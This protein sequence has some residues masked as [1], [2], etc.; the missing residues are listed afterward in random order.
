[1][2][3]L[4]QKR[5]Y[6][7]QN[8]MSALPPIATAKADLSQAVMSALPQKRTF[9]AP[10][11][12]RRTLSHT[13]ARISRPPTMWYIAGPSPKNRMESTTI[14]IGRT[15]V[16]REARTDPNFPPRNANPAYAPNPGTT[17]RKR[18]VMNA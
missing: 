2:S 16:T 1:M 13:A 5:T 12:H 9:G 7:V 3:A 6:A 14:D 15:Y 10:T 18:Y 8:A 11:D 17:A 4:G